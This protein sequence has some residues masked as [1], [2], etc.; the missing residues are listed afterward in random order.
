MPLCVVEVMPGEM[1][2]QK[3][4]RVLPEPGFRVGLKVGTEEK[5]LCLW[6]LY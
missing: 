1:S 5:E 4:V 6:V 3:G 2:A